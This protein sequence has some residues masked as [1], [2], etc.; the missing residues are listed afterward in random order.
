MFF[1]N[2]SAAFDTID[3]QILLARLSSFYG[4][5]GSALTL[6][7][8]YLS[9][10]TQSVSINSIFSSP[11]PVLTG[12]PQGSVLGPLL[13]SL[14]TSPIS[15]TLSN[16]TVSYHLYADD[17][18]LYMSFHSSD[19][20]HN[21]S[22]ISSTLDSVH[23]WL[24]SNRLTVNPAKTEY[25]II[26][27]PQQR[28]KITSSSITFSGNQL[29]P[30]NSCRNLGVIFDSELSL[31]KHISSVC[32]ASYLQIR[33]IRQIRSSLDIRSTTLLANSLVSSRLDYCNSLFYE[34]PDSSLHRLQRIQNSLARAVLPSTKRS[35]HI[36]PVLRKLHWLPIKQRIAF[37]IASLTFKT[38]QNKIPSYLNDLLHCHNP[39]RSLRSSNQLLLVIPRMD[40]ENGR[41]SFSFAAPS[42]WNSLPLSIRSLNT[43]STFRSALKTHLFPAL[44]LLSLPPFFT[45]STSAFHGLSS[46]VTCSL[47]VSGWGMT[48]E[49]CHMRR[50]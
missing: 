24:T 35:D 46:C 1:L 34:L 50:P 5:S 12:V 30:S 27:T 17:T 47:V 4:I 41:R 6:I 36:S 44:K 21:L 2:P 25:L 7:S 40:S 3:H 10:R 32:R 20:I 37:K 22:I 29:K 19:S 13:F 33:Q 11:S 8:S 48:W 45:K 49:F 38:L 26:G 42:V 31:K 23:S 14:Y 28:S 16:S 18:Q 9:N 43:F 15:L 39:S